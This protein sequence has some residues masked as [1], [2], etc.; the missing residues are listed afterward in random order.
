MWATRL[1]AAGTWILDAIGCRQT[2][3]DFFGLEFAEPEIAQLACIDQVQQH[4]AI[5]AFPLDDVR[6]VRQF[7]MLM[8]EVS[9]TNL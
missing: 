1:A 7:K 2:L 6:Q 8:P 3:D 9:M 5:H 4:G